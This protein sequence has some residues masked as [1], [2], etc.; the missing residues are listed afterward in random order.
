MIIQLKGHIVFTDFF[1]RQMVIHPK[2]H[3]LLMM[4]ITIERGLKIKI[5]VHFLFM[6][7][8]HII[9]HVRQKLKNY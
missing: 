1:F 4:D 6:L 2:A 3:D 8:H 5:N 7:V 9:R